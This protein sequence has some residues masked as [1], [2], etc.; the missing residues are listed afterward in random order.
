MK[1]I[2][3]SIIIISSFFVS[4]GQTNG[5]VFFNG[6]IAIGVTDLSQIG[7]NSLA[8]NGTAVF[9]KAK[10]ALY[11]SW[12]DYVFSPDYKLMPLDSLEQFI[13]LNK[14]LPE[15]LSAAEVERNGIDLG[16]NQVLLLKKI[17]ELTLIA[18][19]Q[20]KQTEKL[21]KVIDDQNKK[22]EEQ[23]K[24]LQDLKKELANIFL[25]SCI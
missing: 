22:F 18:I 2:T 5:T 7:T 17:E 3:L 24:A 21:Q 19:E 25:Q 8:V 11:G 10:V 1:K 23:A 13:Q 20:N 14:H 16:D 4:K 6:K 15:V 12:A 9:T